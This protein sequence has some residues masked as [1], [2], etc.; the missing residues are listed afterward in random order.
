MNVIEFERPYFLFLLFLLPF[1][2]IGARRSLAGFSTR[3]LAFA[4]A[5][6]G[7]M[8]L[9]LAGALAS[10]AV[11]TA[12]RKLW[13]VCLV[14]RSCSIAPEQRSAFEARVREI[15]AKAS[16]AGIGTTAVEFAQHPRR[17]ARPIR[18]PDRTPGVEDGETNIAAAIQFARAAFPPGVTKRIVLF[19]DGNET[20]GNAL[21]AAR[22][23]RGEGVSIW[24]FVPPAPARPEFLVERLEAPSEIDPGTP[25]RLRAH[26]RTRDRTNVQLRLYRDGVLVAQKDEVVSA[27]RQVVEFQDR[28]KGEGT[29]T[30]RL[31][32]QAEADSEARNNEGAAIVASGRRPTVLYLEGNERSGRYLARALEAEKIRVHLRGGYGFPTSLQ[33]LARYGVVILSDVPASNMSS[34]QMEL[35]KIYVHDLGGGFVMA[36][37]EESFG[38]G[39][40]YQSA[41]ED[42]LPVRCRPEKRKEHPSI[43]LMLLIDKSGSMSGAKIELAKEAARQT[44]DLLGPDD[45]IGA[46]AFDADA[47]WVAELQSARNKTGIEGRIATIQAGGGTSM[48]PAL[49]MAYDAL[50]NSHASIRHAIVLTDGQT[51]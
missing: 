10:P 21:R 14:D 49:Q 41:V 33:E 48:Y 13:I 2:A 28:P 47:Y 23:A 17:R 39:G 25:V 43:A 11:L 19:S 45:E 8:W 46:V 29:F 42:I 31:L 22:Q 32:A 1:V 4:A 38:L 44:A 51:Q 27:G 15:A 9:L 5:C 40:Y 7:A 3:R 12:T 35:L 6:R 36:G 18:D 37:G 50:L 20:Q 34:A 16:E 30:Y 24:P 26:V